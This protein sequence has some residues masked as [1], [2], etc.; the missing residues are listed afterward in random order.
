MSPISIRILRAILTQR[1]HFIATSISG[2]LDCLS[3]NT[4]GTLFLQND[5]EICFK[6]ATI[7]VTFS[8]QGMK[9]AKKVL[10]AKVTT[11]IV[12]VPTRA[13]LKKSKI[14]VIDEATANVDNATDELIQRSIREKFKDCTVLTIAH[15]LRTVIDNDQIMVLSNGELIEY[16]S[17]YT[18]LDNPLSYLTDLVKQTSPAEC[19]HLKILARIAYLSMSLQK[20]QG[21]I[22]DECIMNDDEEQQI[23]NETDRLLKDK[24]SSFNIIA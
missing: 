13:I 19:E 11:T 21:Q 18:L 22:N 7:T 16:D 5:I 12:L 8:Y 4:L 17:P 14:L 2:E 10:V 23:D 6:D 3:K 9:S 15:R 24:T 20:R 1:N